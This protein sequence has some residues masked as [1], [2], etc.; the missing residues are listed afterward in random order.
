MLK[1]EIEQL[2]ENEFLRIFWVIECLNPKGQKRLI[3]RMYNEEERAYQWGRVYADDVTASH[4]VR[5][6]CERHGY[7]VYQDMLS[8]IEWE[9][10]PKN[11]RARGWESPCI[12]ELQGLHSFYIRRIQI[13]VELQEANRASRQPDCDPERTVR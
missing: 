10:D 13:L 4:V 7:E 1:Q 3:Y 6:M 8:H 11:S 12:K 2:Q 5:Q 9:F